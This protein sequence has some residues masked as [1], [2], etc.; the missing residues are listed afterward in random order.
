MELKNQVLINTGMNRDMSISRADASLA[1][2]NRNI[3]ITATDNDTMVTVT[4]E[5][6]NK[7][8]SLDGLIYGFLVG[9]NVLNNHI[10]L[11]T[12]ANDADRIY[13][14]DYDGENFKSVHAE[15]SPEN[16]LY[17]G[18]LHLD[19]EHPIESVV[20]FESEDVQ[21]IY[22][23]DGKNVLRFANFVDVDSIYEAWNDSTYFDSNRAAK[24]NVSV[25]IDKDN[26]GEAR[27][28]GVVQYIMTY[29]NRYGQ[30]TGYVWASDL[31]YLSPTEYGGTADGYNNNRVTFTLENLDTS[32]SHFRIYSVF[33]S[34][35][36]SGSVSYLVIDQRTSDSKV[37]VSDDGAHLTAA[38][39]YELLY[40]GS[41]PLIAGTLTHKDQTLFLG[42]LQSTGKE[43]Y[44]DLEDVI[45]SSMFDGGR[46]IDGKS[47][48]SKAVTFEYSDD[49][50]D[51]AHDIPYVQ[52]VGN[53]PFESQLSYTSSEILSFK[54]GEKYRFALRFQMRDGTET[55]A[56]WIGD[57]VNPLYPV[58]DVKSGKIK[59]IVAKCTL[60]QQVLSYIRSKTD[61]DGN[62]KYATVR[63]MIAEATSADRAVKAQGIVNPTMFNTWE[64]YNNRLYS[65]PSWISRPRGSAYANKHFDVVHNANETSGEIQ[66]NYWEMPEGDESYVPTPFYQYKNYGEGSMTYTEEFQGAQDYDYLMIVYNVI[67]RND[68]MYWGLAH[69]N[70]RFNITVHVVKGRITNSS[71]GDSALLAYTFDN[72]SFD[73]AN[74][75]VKKTTKAEGDDTDWYVLDKSSDGFVLEGCSFSYKTTSYTSVSGPRK[76][77]YNKVAEK[78]VSLDM[79]TG[80]IVTDSQFKVWTDLAHDKKY[81]HIVT[82]TALYGKSEYS[83][84]GVFSTTLDAMNA[85]PATGKWLRLSDVSVAGNIGALVPAYYKKHLMF[86]DESVVTL[87]SPEI[88]NS[89]VSF[90]NADYKFRIV[91]V[92]KMTS[93]IGDYTI[94]A[95]HSTVPGV[96]VDKENFSGIKSVAGGLR[97]IIT[98]PLWKEYNLTPK[99]EDSANKEFEDREQSDYIIGGS[100]IRYWV[101][102]W[103]K[104]G[105]ISGY[106]SEDSTS[107][108]AY[109]VLNSKTFANLHFS[110]NTIYLADAIGNNKNLDT[111][112]IRLISDSSETYTT[113][114]VGDDNVYHSGAVNM[115]IGLPGNH[116]YPILYSDLR[117]IDTESDIQSDKYYFKTNVPVQLQYYSGPHA[118]IS[119]KSELSDITGSTLFQG[120]KRRTQTLLP[121]FF[122]SEYQDYNISDINEKL[123]GAI[124]PWGNQT[125]EDDD[126]TQPT[127]FYN[128]NQPRLQFYRNHMAADT[129]TENDE[130]LFVGEIYYEPSSALSDTRYG[131]ITLSSV[132]ANRF[133]VAG[134]AYSIEDFN[135]VI[136]GNQ[137]DTYIQRWD[138]LRTKP[139]STSMNNVIDI[140]SVLLETHINLD[141]RTDKQR[142]IKELA[143]IDTANFGTLNP[144]YS[145]KNNFS[146]ARDLDEE[147]NTNV[148]RSSITWTLPKADLASTD[149]WTH[150]TLAST[151][152]LDGDKGVCQALRRMQNSIIAFQDR[153]IAEVLF[154]SRTQLSTADGVPVELANSGK[155]DGKRYIT[156][157]YG[158]IN[159]W[160]ITEGKAGLYFVDNI[161]KSFCM[162]SGEGMKNLSDNLNFGVWFRRE[163]FT[164]A[165]NPRDFKNIVSFYDRIHSDVYLVK[166][167][168]GSNDSNDAP[169]LVYN[170]LLGKFTSFYDYNA[171]PMMANVEDRFVSF[172]NNS[173]WLQNE[174]LY[175]NFFGKQYDFYTTY[176][177]SPDGFTDKIWTNL[178]YR[179]DFYRILDE[180]GMN[181]VK[182]SELIDGGESM[183]SPGIYQADETFN[184]IELWHEYQQTGKS[185]KQPIKKFRTW[186]YAIPRAI[187]TAANKYGLDRMRN[188]WINLMLKYN[189][190]PGSKE[191]QDLMQLHNVII[192]YYI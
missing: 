101:Y 191:S 26:S 138:S 62:C 188:P 177:V 68:N 64:R 34:S 161:N 145:N 21:K 169:A 19:D 184:D 70:H 43:N 115:A 113:M 118:V 182:E 146:V 81:N 185:S 99:D 94:D 174:G 107:D 131:G 105:I 71:T 77:L 39:T 96:T 11:F 159:K 164:D 127:V 73:K 119:L 111:S 60:S 42:D 54:G 132:E 173:L 165:W 190:T 121:A 45:R 59:R 175:C 33:S 112:S 95:T 72:E 160:S 35:Q 30:E 29:Y 1:Y 108:E 58:V 189:Y 40:L 155:V 89:M 104:S 176:R 181:V 23:I 142:G 5:R 93:T 187:K 7:Q 178:D 53:Y 36:A 46:F 103:H 75:W 65:M 149:E 143:S 15:G 25:K 12:H 41:Q 61:S 84:N 126:T 91:G 179:A 170:E 135:G 167:Q 100:I 82:S 154:N 122:E 129:L 152:K 166:R 20:Y 120:N 78:L 14:I 151:L 10:I 180:D 183:L 116:K 51:V 57:R 109:S 88:S 74:G 186:R 86:V 66:C 192:Y 163:N 171:V 85:T 80:F 141:G 37:T 157:K 110:Y 47:W 144:V 16:C 28:N 133:V 128:V 136:Y 98:W 32:F 97:G 17:K 83:N 90:D 49:T 130:Y 106:S 150:I 168:M 3:R 27:P 6:G 69:V 38:D 140:T 8:I 56:F 123:S 55:E 162:F 172:R 156:N 9:W 76:R 102:M 2:D 63:L 134:P 50:N 125:D 153:G 137:G 124:L 48:L 158:C 18:N 148:Y 147:F 87:D 117:Q 31:I 79:P 52:N 22:W 24:F 139:H 92:A 4:N 114:K 67:Y 44:N 13:R